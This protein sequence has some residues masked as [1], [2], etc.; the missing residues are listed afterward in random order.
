MNKLSKQQNFNGTNYLEMSTEQCTHCIE[1]FK[2]F[3]NYLLHSDFVTCME[4]Y[5]KNSLQQSSCNDKKFG[6]HHLKLC[7][8]YQATYK[9]HVKL[10]PSKNNT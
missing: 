10:L 7:K 1:N 6:M 2:K 5:S 9:K 3:E 8:K 4:K